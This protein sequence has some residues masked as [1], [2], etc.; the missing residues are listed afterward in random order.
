MIVLQVRICT[1]IKQ[2]W[3]EPL[4]KRGRLMQRCVALF[5]LRINIGSLFY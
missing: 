2:V 4:S 3:C 1:F 5:I